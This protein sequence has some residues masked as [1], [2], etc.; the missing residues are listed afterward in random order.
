[1]ASWY[2][3]KRYRSI[4]RKGQWKTDRWKRKRYNWNKPKRSRGLFWPKSWST[5][6]WKIKRVKNWKK[7][8]GKLRNIWVKPSFDEGHFFVPEKE[9]GQ[10]RQLRREQRTQKHRFKS[11][12][13]ATQRS[14]GGLGSPHVPGSNA[15]SKCCTPFSRFH[16]YKNQ[17]SWEWVPVFLNS[18]QY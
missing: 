17:R 4:E 14:S 11:L 8:N 3:K 2:Y 6:V 10:F 1:M 5:I 12:R 7:E 18:P 13:C 9:F 15:A 16:S